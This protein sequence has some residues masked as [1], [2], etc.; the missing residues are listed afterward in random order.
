MYSLVLLLIEAFISQK[1]YQVPG[2]GYL[3]LSCWSWGSQKILKTT[4]SI[5][6]ILVFPFDI[7][8]NPQ[9]DKS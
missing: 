4:N 8:S 1:K 9:L 2:I 5:F 3:F 7:P 6:I